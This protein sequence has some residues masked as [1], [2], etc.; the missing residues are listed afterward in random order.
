MLFYHKVSNIK[1][2]NQYYLLSSI[3][4]F[5]INYIKI[6]KANMFFNISQNY[7]TS[8]GDRY[9]CNCINFGENMTL[10]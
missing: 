3:H 2:K 4:N 8:T 1:K 5:I 10:N 7:L 6:R 9:L